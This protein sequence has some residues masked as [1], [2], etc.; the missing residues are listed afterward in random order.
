LRRW[1]WFLV[2][3]LSAGAAFNIRPAALLPLGAIFLALLI[4]RR[5]ATVWLALGVMVALLPQFMFN[6]SRGILGLPVPERTGWL[7]ELQSSYAPFIVRYD[8]VIA[9]TETP[10]SVSFCSPRMARALEGAVPTS[11]GELAVTYLERLPE[12]LAMALQK[13]GAALHWPLSSPYLTPAPVLNAVFALLI[14]AVTVIGASVLLRHAFGRSHSLTFNR[15]V[16]LLAWAGSLVGLVTSVTETRFA[17]ALVLLGI[18]GC[19]VL[20]A[21]GLRPGQERSARWWVAGAV[22]A[23]VALYAVGVT[24]M[25]HVFPF[26]AG[27]E[28]CTPL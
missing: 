21:D 18:V 13:I 16:V 14:T 27:L 2:A 26:L 1:P 10:P 15:I 6:R 7:S 20:A 24:G 12:S 19:A 5:S 3:G 4:A 11:P 9:V 8:T 28:D 17:L 22:A 25:V 23:V